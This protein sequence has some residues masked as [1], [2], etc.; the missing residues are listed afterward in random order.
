MLQHFSQY[1]ISGNSQDTPMLMNGLKKCDIHM[2]LN[3]IQ[4]QG[5]MKFCHLQ[6]NG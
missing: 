2:Q 5:R 1:L 4:P 6:L 3:F